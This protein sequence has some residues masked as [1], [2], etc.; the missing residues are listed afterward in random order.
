MTILAPLIG[1]KRK[2]TNVSHVHHP[3]AFQL[4][5]HIDLSARNMCEPMILDGNNAAELGVRH[6]IHNCH[7]RIHIGGIPQQAVEWYR[8]LSDTQKNIVT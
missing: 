6:N 3:Q 7:S 2:D 5:M 8:N 4:S 1:T